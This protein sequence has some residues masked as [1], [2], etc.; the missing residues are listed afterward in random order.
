M[1][2]KIDIAEVETATKIRAKYLRALENDEFGLLPGSTFVK[3]FLR[4]YAEYLGLDA[5]LLVEE[6]RVHY[7]PR[8]ESEPMQHF[9]SRQRDAPRR[10]RYASRPPG[11]GT[12]LVVVVLVVLVLF[13]VLGITGG[14]NKSST[15]S[16][17]AQK[18]TPAKKNPKPKPKPAPPPKPTR[19]T[20]RVVPLSGPT[21][22]CV[23]RGA[24]GKKVFE[25][26]IP[27]ARK[28]RGRKIR[29]TIGHTPVKL[30]RNGKRVKIPPTTGAVYY[31][32]TPNRAKV[33]RFGQRA[34]SGNATGT[35]TGTGTG[36]AGTTG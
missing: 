36:A 11:P 21:Y 29:I 31:Q 26:I 27:A 8:G 18:S 2:Q 9:A 15:S 17:S 7:E 20:V 23:D 33:L 6:Y 12:A 25:G 35:G 5:T 30:T 1:R 28:F 14:S 24:G 10:S 16:Q 3:T 22:I 13:A 19:V 32:L 34:C 4:T